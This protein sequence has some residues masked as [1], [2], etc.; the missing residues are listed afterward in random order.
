[1]KW[2][3]SEKRYK[4]CLQAISHTLYVFCLV[5]NAPPFLSSVKILLHM[6]MIPLTQWF[7]PA[8]THQYHFL[9]SGTQKGLSWVGC[10]LGSS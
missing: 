6:K 9:G 10:G 4:R 7:K 3:M 8:N 2:G 1:M 5:V